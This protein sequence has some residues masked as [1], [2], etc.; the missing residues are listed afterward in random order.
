MGGGKRL[1][2]FII[3]I[4]AFTI[5]A[6][7]ISCDTKVTEPTTT[8]SSIVVSTT[9]DN[10]TSTTVSST[11]LPS[12]TLTSNSTSTST[13]STSTSIV[14][15]TTLD[16]QNSTST[17]TTTTT[18]ENKVALPTFD[19]DA[20]SFD[21]TTDIVISCATSG[22]A[23][24]YTIDGVTTPTANSTQYTTPIKITYGQTKTI[25]A[26]AIKS[27]MVGSDLAERTYTVLS[28]VARPQF[29]AATGTKFGVSLTV[30]ISSST[31]GVAI[32]YSTD[33]TNWTAGTS[34]SATATVTLKAR[35]KKSGMATSEII[36]A[37]YIQEN[38]TLAA[39]TFSNSTDASNADLL[40]VTC[41]DKVTISATSADKILYRIQY[42]GAWYPATGYTEVTGLSAVI[43][44]GTQFSYATLNKV[45]AKAIKAGYND[46]HVVT[47]DFKKVEMIVVY[48]STTRSIYKVVDNTLIAWGTNSNSDTFINKFGND[49]YTFVNT[50][51]AVYKNNVVSG[52][53]ITSGSLNTVKIVR[54][55]ANLDYYIKKN[56]GNTIFKLLDAGGETTWKNNT[57]AYVFINPTSNG[58]IWARNS[59][60]P[61]KVYKLDNATEEFTYDPTIINYGGTSSGIVK[62][63]TTDKYFV[64][65]GSDSKKYIYKNGQSTS[66]VIS[67]FT[68]TGLTLV[69][70]RE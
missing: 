32:E 15:S 47:R 9:L 70:I 12:T 35:A 62:I 45:E 31:S 25:K 40:S 23:I 60:T 54:N 13:T 41:E 63:N 55:G 59:L 51:T 37:T 34:Y 17:T 56:S 27:G 8:T 30:N 50:G 58:D 43:E 68:T 7:L 44:A 1:L 61:V 69:D 24:Y 21:A 53:G 11:T 39:P 42:N 16:N 6:T 26:V 4:T 65:N 66:N 52:Y 22:A 19:K 64:E 10:Q 57:S 46:S 5:L 3:L 2:I 38:P 14:V 29:D 28:Q 33:G 20:G 18:I 36:E 48:N 67:S 49:V